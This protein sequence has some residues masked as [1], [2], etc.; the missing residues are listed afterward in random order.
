MKFFFNELELK[1]NILILKIFFIIN[2]M[3]K[4]L[5]S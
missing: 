4:D 5:Y 2:L 3:M 1:I